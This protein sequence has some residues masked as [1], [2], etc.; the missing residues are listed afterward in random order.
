MVHRF[1]KYYRIHFQTGHPV[2]GGGQ[3]GRE[4]RGLQAD[5]GAGPGQRGGASRPGPAS[6]Q[7]P[8]AQRA[9][10]GGDDGQ[11]EGPRQH[12]PAAVRAVHA[13]L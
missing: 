5:P 12:D 9:H 8:G 3:A 6:A 13:E 2:R 7:D 4:S 11:A 1:F 10:E